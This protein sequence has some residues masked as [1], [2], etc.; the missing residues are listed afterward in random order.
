MNKDIKYAWDYHE[1]TKHS[2]ISLMTQRHYLDFDNRPIPFK[3]YTTNFPLYPLPSDFPQPMLDAIS[4]VSTLNPRESHHNRTNSDGNTGCRTHSRKIDELDI[5]D[6]AAILFFSAGITR[7]TNYNAMTYYMRAASATGALYP[8]ELYVVSQDLADLEAGLYHFCPADF[9]LVQVRKG[10]YRSHLAAGVVNGHHVLSSP[11]SI[12]L[13][14]FAWRNAWKYQA[15]SY[16]HWFWDSGVITAN[17][18]ATTVAMGLYINLKMAFLD[19]KVNRLL[20][21][22]SNK[23]AVVIIGTIS[24]QELG[25]SSQEDEQKEK[26]IDISEIS[27]PKIRPLSENEINYPEIWRLHDAS[28]LHSLKEAME[29]INGGRALSAQPSGNQFSSSST[30]IR[31]L[32]TLPISPSQQDRQYATNASLAEVILMRGSTRRFSKSLI[33]FKTL[34]SIL[35]SSTRGIP[36]DFLGRDNLSLIDVYLICNDIEDLSAGGYFYNRKS[37]TLDLLKMQ[38]SREIA[39]YLCLGQS[40]F[41]QASAVLFLMTDLYKVLN[42]LGNRGYRASQFEAGVIAGKIYLSAYAHGI[43]ASGS[44]FFDDAVTEFFSPHADKKST[45]IVVGIGK[46]A[47]KALTGKILPVRLTRDQLLNSKL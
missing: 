32:N 10:D 45:M 16:R 12:I 22:D 33:P 1:A 20:R 40:L 31:V 35:Y 13:T 7:A 6:L 39:G 9:S 46:P 41:T 28:K 23:E 18:L 8:I 21:L 25:L 29:W 44:T 24:G 47:Y 4:A 26:V 11:I 2:E 34:S 3:I 43:G 27:T 38:T 19:D 37:N 17:L 15:R 14:S 36:I 30:G 5:R 42:S